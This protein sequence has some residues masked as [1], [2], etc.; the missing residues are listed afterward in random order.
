MDPS[1]KGQAVGKYRVHT[2]ERTYS[3]V[4]RSPLL[5]TDPELFADVLRNVS[6]SAAFSEVAVPV[7]LLKKFTISI[8]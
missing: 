5:P 1:N 7:N 4:I 8:N 2:N 3:P 6:H